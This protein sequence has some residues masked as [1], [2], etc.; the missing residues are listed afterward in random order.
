VSTQHS[1]PIPAR[2][3]TTDAVR[4]AALPLTGSTTD[5]DG[6]VELI[7]NA[8]YVLL[9]QASHGTE[10]FYRERALITR[11]LIEEC[12]FVAVAVEADWPDAYRVNRYVQGSVEFSSADEALAGFGRFP[13][14]MWRNGAVRDFSEWL[15]AYNGEQAGK[16][17]VGFYGLDLYSLHSSM[18]AVLHYLESVDPDAAARARN[19]YACFED[20]DHDVGEYGYAA[21]LGLVDSCERE[22][23][24]QLVELRR[25][26]VEYSR[27]NG[28][29]A[30]EEFFIAEQNA[31]LV[32]NA[33]SYYRTMFRSRVGAWNL[34]AHHMAESFAALVTHLGQ[35]IAEPKAV[36]WAH[37]AHVG[38]ARGTEARHRGQF[39]MGQLLRER[40]G[41]DV[42]L[43]GFSTHG[44]WVTAA[45]QWGADP[46]RKPLRPAL[47]GSYEA[48]FHAT[49][50]SRFLLRLRQQDP[51]VEHLQDPRLE[52]AIGVI[53]RPE[54]ERMS[55]YVVAHLPTQFDAILHYDHTHSLETLPSV[56]QWRAGEP[57][58]T[59][60]SGL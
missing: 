60:P 53:Y 42:V 31:R 16:P 19:R 52:R 56:V 43:V 58:E 29:G 39:N 23:V 3:E 17:P 27:R 14:W 30:A 36:I 49:G 26:A 50:L 45:N 54:T 7:G 44:G 48:L 32:K 5:F 38:D 33:E 10:E 24:S 9:G 6:L 20:F 37:N 21:G 1:G 12:G 25:Q 15:R 35:T 34:R 47:E 18:E 57:A 41:R 22:A 46:E 59:Y 28:A 8:P 11:R 2:E 51:V 40:Y 13:E 4:G 55:H